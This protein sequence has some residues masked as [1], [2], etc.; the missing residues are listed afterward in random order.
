ML[1]QLAIYLLGLE[2][3]CYAAAQAKERR[4]IQYVLLSF[5]M[6][7]L[8]SLLSMFVIGLFVSGSYWLALPISLLGTFVFISIFRFSLILIKPEL[9]ILTRLNEVVLQTTLKEKWGQIIVG[10][11]NLGQ[12]LKTI[13]WNTN[14]AIPGFTVVFRMLYMG[15]LAFVL[16][17]PLTTLF[18][19]SATMEFNDS[20]RQ[21]A[22]ENYRKG[23]Y[24]TPTINGYAAERQLSFYEGKVS[25]EY[26]TMQL[27]Q[28]ATTYPEFILVALF[29]CALLFLPHALLFM[30]M[31]N[32]DFSYVASLNAHFKKLIEANYAQLEIGAVQQLSKFKAFGS[33]H[34]ISFLQ[35]GNPYIEEPTQNTRENISWKELQNRMAKTNTTTNPT[36]QV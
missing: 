36:V 4:Y 35:K 20:L 2:P 11:K 5:S 9:K 1:D 14:I 22:L 6:V 27:F 7:L 13:R 33:T 23:V 12:K 34:D 29:V 18:H 3:A 28:K 19:W 31:R 10:F 8:F 15:L 25:H 32:K 30:M 16:V 17:F 24:T 26:F 21:E